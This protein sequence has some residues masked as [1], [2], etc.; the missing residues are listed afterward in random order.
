MSFLTSRKCLIWGALFFVSCGQ[1]TDSQRLAETSNN[2]ASPV[3]DSHAQD[4]FRQEFI[5]RLN[6]N[7]SNDDA[8]FAAPYLPPEI[9][10]ESAAAQTED[11]IATMRSSLATKR[12]DDLRRNS[13][14]PRPGSRA[15]PSSVPMTIV[16]FPCI[17][18]EFAASKPFGDLF[19]PTNPFAQ[20]L[21]PHLRAATTHAFDPRLLRV[22]TRPLADTLRVTRIESD[23]THPPLQF[24]SLEP[25]PGSL[26]SIGYVADNARIFLSRLS[27]TF[28]LM[29]A[30]GHD[31]SRIYFFGYS[32]G[33][34]IALEALVQARAQISQFPWS[35][36]I[37]G[38]ISV[39]GVLFGA[40]LADNVQTDQTNHIAQAF[41]HFRN[42]A[43]D[44]EVGRSPGVVWRNGRRW[45]QAA[46]GLARHTTEGIASM[47]SGFLREFIENR[48]TFPGPKKILTY[49]KGTFGDIF[50]VRNPIR[51]YLENT[52]RIKTFLQSFINCSNELTTQYRRQWWKTHTVPSDVSYYAM[53]ALQADAT[54]DLSHPSPAVSDPFYR[55]DTPESFI[56]RAMYYEGMRTSGAFLSDGAVATEQ[57]RFWPRVMQKWNPQQE[58]ISA[59]D[60]GVVSTHHLAVAMGSTVYAG[61]KQENPFPR[62][63]LAI[64]LAA[65]VER[66]EKS[67]PSS[68]GY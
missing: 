58:P 29:R 19:S 37:R 20:E 10:A 49:L 4:I 62:H 57:A 13:H 32:R 11:P 22:T 35:R 65:S 64:S 63:T 6:D 55:P 41:S 14:S 46:I 59:Y 50:E 23:G 56:L 54:V 61:P 1:A 9:F 67:E 3:Q 12:V 38:I 36:N 52:A 33:G 66:I 45:E 21:A 60:L 44:L 68:K 48:L 27:T 42:L 15:T 17:L 53:S 34:P 18:G 26:E 8:N 24:I 39:S 47:P 30:A 5:G 2:T 28:A 25:Q 7:W 16:I 51:G 40:T 43:A 31:L